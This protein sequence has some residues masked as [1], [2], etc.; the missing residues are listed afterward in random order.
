MELL[1]DVVMTA[2]MLMSMT[3][4]MMMLLMNMMFSLT[5]MEIMLVLMIIM[6]VIMIFLKMRKKIPQV[7]VLQ[8]NSSLI[9][10]DFLN[11]L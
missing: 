1:G 2:M 11:Y 9:L 6:L 7:C 8:F 4:V 5:Q 10:V 3:L